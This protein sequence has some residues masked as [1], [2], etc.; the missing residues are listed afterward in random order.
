[1]KE[2]QRL[3]ELLPQYQ[4]LHEIRKGY[5][6]RDANGNLHLDGMCTTLRALEKIETGEPM[7]AALISFGFGAPVWVAMRAVEC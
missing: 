7:C 1:M 3:H 4:D 2:A 6:R 5:A